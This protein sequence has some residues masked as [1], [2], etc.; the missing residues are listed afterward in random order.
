MTRYLSTFF[1]LLAS[2][3]SINALTCPPRDNAGS[4]LTSQ[5][6]DGSFTVCVYPVAR[7]CEYFSN[8][9]FSSGSSDCPS[10]ISRREPEPEAKAEVAT[11]AAAVSCPPR[12]NAGS[13][14]LSTGMDGSF[15]VCVY[16]VARTCEYFSNGGFSSGSSDCPS[17]I[18][19]REVE[20]EARAAAV[21]CPPRDNAGSPLLSTGTDG[22]FIVCVYQ[23][24]RTCEYFSNGGFSSGSSDCPSSISRREVEVEARAAAVSCP[25]RDNAGSPLLST[26]TDGGFIVCVY[27]VARTCEYF[28]NGGFSSGSSDCPSS[29]SRREVE[30]EARAA[31]VSCPPRDNAGSPL[32]STGTDGS[33]IVCV[34]QVARTCEYFSN[35]GFSSGSS[36]CPSSISRRE[37]KKRAISAKFARAL[38]A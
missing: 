37:E 38:K 8:G 10:S 23:V 35:G 24:A 20:V 16:Q 17:S 4:R 12:D 32:L 19:R 18:S 30:V 5:S 6:M 14:L 21:S 11:R 9:S 31:A 7:T 3:L 13:P 26:G 2:A 22:G 1:V 28:S 36:D 27:Q 33:F 34:Y 25:P 15:I 29:I